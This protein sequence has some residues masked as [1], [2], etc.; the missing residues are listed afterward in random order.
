M[1][2]IA[3]IQRLDPRVLKSGRFK[4]R[5]DSDESALRKLIPSIRANGVRRPL[6]VVLDESDSRY[7]VLAGGLRWKAALQLRLTQVPVIVRARVTD[8]QAL[9]IALADNIRD[10][11]L[12]A[13]EEG[14]A[15]TLLVSMGMTVQAIARRLEVD[16]ETVKDMVALA[17][18]DEKSRLALR[19]LPGS[20][21]S[22]PGASKAQHEID[23]AIPLVPELAGHRHEAL[24]S[25]SGTEVAPGGNTRLT[26]REKECLLR[27]AEG[28][29]T[30]ETSQIVGVSSWTVLFHFDNAA[31]KL[32][33]YNHTH[34]VARAISQ[35]I[36]SPQL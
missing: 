6:V 9:I 34:A 28:K 13:F 29:T 32:G 17:Q 22:L 1:S 4:I 12:S 7:E 35:S 21:W 15:Y 26:K 20:I 19:P 2:V 3:K 33:V 36:I 30:W 23:D 27:V 11:T 25:V 31:R 14:E 5:T 16:V 18:L 24:R 10:D 8:S